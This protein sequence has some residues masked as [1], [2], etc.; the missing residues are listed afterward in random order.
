MISQPLFTDFADGLERDRMRLWELAV[1]E[2]QR[3]LE[4]SLPRLLWI[5]FNST[6]RRLRRHTPSWGAIL[7]IRLLSFRHRA[8]FTLPLNPEGRSHRRSVGPQLLGDLI[9]PPRGQCSGL[10][11]KCPR[12][13]MLPQAPARLET[14]AN[15]RRASGAPTPHG[16]ASGPSQATAR[17]T[18]YLQLESL[19]ILASFAMLACPLAHALKLL[20][21]SPLVNT[22][23]PTL[24]SQAHSRLRGETRHKDGSWSAWASGLS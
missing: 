19:D 12:R 21:S 5:D 1:N 2:A 24:W 17:G 23:T 22:L 8:G 4:G 18:A 15:G 9:T 10:E 11:A 3:T 13:P 14:Q 7:P 20:R 16:L 6:T